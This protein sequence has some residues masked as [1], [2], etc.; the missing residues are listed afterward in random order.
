MD[1]LRVG[2]WMG[3]AVCIC[4]CLGNFPSFN[5]CILDICGISGGVHG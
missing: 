5:N 2:T 1:I 3:G 4:M